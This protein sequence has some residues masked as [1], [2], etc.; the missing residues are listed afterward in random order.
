MNCFINLCVLSSLKE[1]AC[2]SVNEKNVT[3]RIIYILFSSNTID[4]A[5]LNFA[6]SY[7]FILNIK[8][9][10]VLPSLVEMAGTVELADSHKLQSLGNTNMAP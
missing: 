3:I 5:Q 7:M 10:Y 9:T 8:S 6:I 1:I 4:T 2:L